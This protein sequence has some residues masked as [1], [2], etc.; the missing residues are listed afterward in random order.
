M[1]REFSVIHYGEVSS[2][3]GMCGIAFCEGGICW[4]QFGPGLS[5]ELAAEYPGAHFV[6]DVEAV[7]QWASRVF[8]P[9]EQAK[10]PVFIEGTP[11]QLRVWEELRKVPFG[12]TIS[13]VE[14]AERVGRPEA[15]Q[16]IAGAIARNPVSVLI[17]SHRV[18]KSSGDLGDYRWGIEVKEL[19]LAWEQTPQ[20]FLETPLVCAFDR[21]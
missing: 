9:S 21:Q 7:A 1:S 10:L 19:L 17:P 8:D 13:Y 6:R 14:L 11:F 20:T 4:V 16:A 5:A 18:V 3:V 12:H 2:P 15:V